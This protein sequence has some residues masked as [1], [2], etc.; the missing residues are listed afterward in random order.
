LPPTDPDYY[1]TNAFTDYAIR[2]VKEQTDTRPFFLYLAYN[3]PHWPLHAKPTDIEPFKD[4]YKVGWDVIRQERL[5]RQKQMGLIARGVGISAR[6]KRVRAWSALSPGEKDSTAYRMAV[7]AAQISSLDQ[8]VGKL[9]ATL[10]EQGQFD[11]TL[12]LFLSDNGACAETYDELGSRP[13]ALI[14]DPSFGGP[15]SYGIGWANAS[16][17]PF[18]EYK[19]KPYEGGI[20]APLIAHFPNGIRTQRGRISTVQGHI[21]DLMPTILAATGAKYPTTF[22]DGQAIFSLEGQSLMPAL[23]TGK[24]PDRGYMYWEHQWYGAV[25]KGDWKAVYDLNKETWELYNV[26][27][28]QIEAKNEAANQPALL[29]DLREHWQLWASSHAVLPKKK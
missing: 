24:L 6:D 23:Q 18:F 11:N 10:K 1:T 2:F 12:I 17:T 22:H 20:R 5:A 15:V 19:V 28:D 27:T 14:N 21:T 7:Y 16:N 13:M 29:A 25:R 3:A 26:V 8:N 4:R 9:V